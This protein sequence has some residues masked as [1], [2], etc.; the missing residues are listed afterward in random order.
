MKDVRSTVSQ[1]ITELRLLNN[2]TQLELAEKLNYS[3]KAISKWERG[4]SLPD[5]A[6][7]VTIADLFG[8]SLDRLVREEGLAEQ[9]QKAK[10]EK[11]AY[12]RRAVGYVSEGAVWTI[13]FLA[14]TITSLVSSTATFAWL[15]FVYALPISLVVK[16]VF[17][18]IWFNPRHNYFIISALLWSILATVHT[19]FAYFQIDISLIYLLGVVGQVII[20]IWSFIKKPKR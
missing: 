18:S 2:M 1:N 13:A 12:N 14:F 16:L 11:A 20:I 19:T 6:V 7:L 17:N 8:V 10:P 3:D 9:V 15:Y 4:E 5:V